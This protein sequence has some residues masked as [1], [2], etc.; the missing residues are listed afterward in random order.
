MGTRRSR[1]PPERNPPPTLSLTPLST[2]SPERRVEHS[3]DLSSLDPGTRV[4]RPSWLRSSPTLR[5]HDLCD[6][7]PMTTTPRKPRG[8]IWGQ[9]KRHS[10]DL[11]GTGRGVR[12]HRV[13]S[14]TNGEGLRLG[15]DL[16]TSRVVK[17]I[18]RFKWTFVWS[19]RSCS[20]TLLSGYLKGLRG[21]VVSFRGYFVTTRF[22]LFSCTPEERFV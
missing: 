17:D 16:G 20:S 2:S 13:K 1:S 3:V 5:T 6:L 8:W 21:T 22:F 15:R 11:P 12:D 14:P 9:K 7:P 18:G 4:V 19:L 10:T